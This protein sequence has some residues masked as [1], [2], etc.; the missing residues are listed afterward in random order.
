MWSEERVCG[1]RVEREVCRARKECEER[2]KC[3]RSVCGGRL[4]WVWS[5][6]RLCV[7]GGLT[8]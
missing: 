2:G 7:V 4:D 8:V 5:E 3:V 1:A 6:V